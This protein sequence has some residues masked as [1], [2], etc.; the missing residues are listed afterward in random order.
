[1]NGEDV[2][3]AEGRVRRDYLAADVGPLD[4]PLLTNSKAHVYYFFLLKYANS[5][6]S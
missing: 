2:R 5:R 3:G 1:M 4:N 6:S